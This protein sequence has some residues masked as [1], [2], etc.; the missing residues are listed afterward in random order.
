MNKSKEII[1]IPLL[2]DREKNQV[3]DFLNK[4]FRVNL[5]NQK[6]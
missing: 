5:I 6:F 4:I 3:H 2:A 1:F